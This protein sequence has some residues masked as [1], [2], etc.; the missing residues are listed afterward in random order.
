VV[1]DQNTVVGIVSRIDVLD[2]MS[3]RGR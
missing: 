2:Y 1:V 3:R